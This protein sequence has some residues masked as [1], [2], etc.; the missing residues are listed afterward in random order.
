[1]QALQDFLLQHWQLCIAA[2]IIL[3]LILTNE[4]YV[5]KNAPKALSPSLAI[6]MMNH[7]QAIVLDLRDAEA[8]RKAHI[9][10]AIRKSLED[11][12]QSELKEDKNTP[13]ILVCAQGMQSRIAAEKLKQQG[14]HQAMVLTG[15]MTA[16]QAAGLPIVKGN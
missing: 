16:W 14:F 12:Q 6:K 3:L 1:M 9:I 10:H 2:I 11:L 7:H 13:I 15:G 8:F 5:R 4:L